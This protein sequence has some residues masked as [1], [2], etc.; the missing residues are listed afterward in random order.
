MSIGCCLIPDRSISRRA[1]CDGARRIHHRGSSPSV[2][3]EVE[4]VELGETFGKDTLLGEIRLFA[5]DGR[6]TMTVR[7][8]AYV[9]A[10]M[11]KYDQL[12]ELYF[13]NPQLD[14]VCC[15]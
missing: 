11:I 9:H 4:T 2:S 7:C 8:N 15:T 5:P 6:R 10:A 1:T 13:Q 14:S 12:E 3:G